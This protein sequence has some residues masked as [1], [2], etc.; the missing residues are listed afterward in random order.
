M[1]FKS[2]DKVLSIYLRFQFNDYFT[3]IPEINDCIENKADKTQA[4]LR[5]ILSG[6]GNDDSNTTN[7]FTTPL[8]NRHLKKTESVVVFL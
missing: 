1:V 7:H 8:C 4:T 6:A 2:L 5:E 3:A